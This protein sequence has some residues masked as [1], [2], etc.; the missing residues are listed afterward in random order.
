MLQLEGELSASSRPSHANC[1]LDGGPPWQFVTH[2][3]QPVAALSVDQTEAR[4][5]LGLV[6]LDGDRV[7]DVSIQPGA[8]VGRLR[9]SASL[10][11]ANPDRWE[12]DLRRELLAGGVSEGW[13]TPAT[14]DPGE[15]DL[16]ALAARSAWPLLRLCT[17]DVR[18]IP[19]WAAGL[20]RGP[21]PVSAVRRQFG[22]RSN[23]PLIR[24]MAEHLSGSINWWSLACVLA[25]HSMDADRAAT[26]LVELGKAEVDHLCSVDEFRLLERTIGAA[27]AP[28]AARLLRSVD[29]RGPS[30]L[31]RALDN[32]DRAEDRVGPLRPTVAE[33]ERRLVQLGE[34]S[35]EP[36]VRAPEPDP[37]ERLVAML[38]AEGIEVS[39]VADPDPRSMPARQRRVGQRP[40]ERQAVEHQP[41]DLRMTE[42]A[43]ARPD[44]QAA[45]MAPSV[46]PVERP[47]TFDHPPGA[48][49]FHREREGRVDLL[50]PADPAHLVEWARLLRNCLHDYVDPVAAGESMILGIRVDEQL[51]GAIELNRGGHL[52][53]M[54]GRANR[55]LPDWVD[56]AVLAVLARVRTR[57][58]S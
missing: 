33:L 17:D 52:R 43:G 37:V 36:A 25:A 50:L 28:V 24:A 11:G 18:E 51:V 42:R 27:P 29:E 56:Q 47:I 30:R 45:R 13:W 53:Q 48:R 6:F 16:V 41:I 57:R 23:R 40:I 2:Q 46:A 21:D 31:L 4:V 20:L 55:P 3:N 7:V 1:G 5:R 12:A 49:A 54:L 32:W 15:L 44:W 58:L 34:P 9:H 35:L 19:R 22:D 14:G 38:D 39:T 10:S 8:W 26:V